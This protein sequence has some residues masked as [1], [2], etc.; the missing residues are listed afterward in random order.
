M[1]NEI[2]PLD[3]G[4]TPENKLKIYSKKAI[5]G[6]SIFFTSIFGGVLLFHNLK[7][8]GKSKEANLIL[9]FSIFFT[10]ISIYIVNI[11]EKPKTGLNYLCN[12]VGGL[13]LT[14]YFFKKYFPAPDD[15][16]KKKIWKP[17]IISILITIPFILAMIYT[18]SLEK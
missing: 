1:D 16:D 10:V 4:V 12:M 11:P 17:L 15:Y 2:K 18:T 7:D 13:I 14:E 3:E 9:I 5:W 8:I 6:F